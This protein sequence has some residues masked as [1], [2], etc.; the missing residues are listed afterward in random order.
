MYGSEK[1]KHMHRHGKL[2]DDVPIISW[3]MCLYCLTN[4]DNIYYM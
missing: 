2:H 3:L 4:S 1:V